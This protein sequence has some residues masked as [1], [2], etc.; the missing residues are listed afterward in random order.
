M[1]MEYQSTQRGGTSHENNSRKHEN[2]STTRNN[3]RSTAWRCSSR[4][5]D[6]NQHHSQHQSGNV[7]RTH[8]THNFCEFCNKDGHTIE[9]CWSRN[10]THDYTYRRSQSRNNDAR[11]DYHI[12]NEAATPKPAETERTSER[13]ND[14]AR[15]IFKGHGT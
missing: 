8:Y 4:V 9:A 2:R 13:R 15:K 14:D 11:V 1:D 12:V 5:N 7:T 6:N 10:K 3:N